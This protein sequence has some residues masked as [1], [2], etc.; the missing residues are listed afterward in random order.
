MLLGGLA[1][2]VNLAFAREL[3]TTDPVAHLGR[4]DEPVPV[5]I[6]RKE[7]RAHWR[8]VFVAALA[9]VSSTLGT[10]AYF[11]LLFPALGVDPSVLL[12]QGAENI[13]RLLVGAG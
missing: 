10:I 4:V 9:N 7:I 13:W 8:V 6:G 2:P 12:G 5:L 1:S 11:V 3:W